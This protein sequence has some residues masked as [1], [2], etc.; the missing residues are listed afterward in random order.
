MQNLKMAAD[1]GH[2]G[3]LK[4]LGQIYMM[5]DLAPQNYAES[6]NLF[7]KAAR[8]GDRDAIRL[9]AHQ[10]ADGLG[11]PAD[12]GRAARLYR[13]LARDDDAPARDWLKAH[14]DAPADPEI[15]DLEKLPRD[16]I[17]YATET[18]DPR[19]QTLDVHGY[20]DQ[21]SVSAYPADA[22]NDGV[23]GEATAECR[24]MP[25]GDFDDC[26]LTKESPKNYGFGASL[27]RIMDR[28]GSSGNKTDWA[29]R[30]DGK[31]LRVSM[32]WKIK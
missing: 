6:L 31:V 17:F 4:E 2:A 16:V 20:F 19:F 28:L 7:K 5:G 9:M 25:S 11:T 27:M 12:L 18:N 24:F 3:A 8:R 32:K 30:F 26:V 10:Y 23:S 13:I 15:L 14:P 29:R 1:Q 21:L 22:Q